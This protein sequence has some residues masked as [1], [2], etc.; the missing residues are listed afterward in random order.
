M[1]ICIKSGSFVFRKSCSQFG[2][3]RTDGQ[4]ENVMLLHFKVMNIEHIPITKVYAMQNQGNGV[5]ILRI[6]AGTVQ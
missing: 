2:D 3:R 6:L 1:P 4:L 5:S